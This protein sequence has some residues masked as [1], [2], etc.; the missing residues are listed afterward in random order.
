MVIKGVDPVL[1]HVIEHILA[2]QAHHHQRLLLHQ[3]VY[4]HHRRL[5]VIKIENIMLQIIL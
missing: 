5:N 2:R 1:D 4:L 3:L